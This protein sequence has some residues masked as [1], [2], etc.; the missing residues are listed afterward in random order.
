MSRALARH[1]QD[2]NA[3]ATEALLG[4]AGK[5]STF[6]CYVLESSALDRMEL[7]L[8]KEKYRRYSEQIRDWCSWG[9]KD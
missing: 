3:K 4:M 1:L 7:N 2:D 5:N 8:F 9:R 6:V